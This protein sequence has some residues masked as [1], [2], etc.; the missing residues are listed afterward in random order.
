MSRIFTTLLCFFGLVLPGL[1]SPV[2]GG[3][4]GTPREDQHD[5]EGPV[6]TGYAV[7]TPV[8]TVSSGLVVFE[9]FGLKQESG[10]TQAGVLP[11]NLTTSA[12]MFA[13]SNGR[14]S[15]NLG[16]AIVNPFNAS[17]TVTLTL[18]NS[19]GATIAT[20]PITIGAHQQITR[21]VTELFAGQGSVPLEFS[22]MLAMTA[23]N[24]IS[25]VGLRFRG[26]NFSAVP[27]TSLSSTTT[28]LPLIATGIGGA[29]A[30][31]LPQF[32]T[33]GGWST[34]VVMANTGTASLTVRLDIFKPD[35]TALTAPLN[36]TSSNTYTNITIPAGGVVTF[37]P[38]DI[39]G[40][41]RF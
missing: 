1:A 31:L 35:G 24:P 5:D 7:I 6:Q 3:G 13:G 2:Q 9:T 36:G 40:D 22:G 8:S 12:V 37:A 20:T 25:V 23:N 30:F 14:L 28:P 15:R 21:F 27:V 26:M 29:G 4:F 33:G 32:A 34:E 18:R 41:S 38:R 11:P 17:V 19:D 39:N 16:V 10:T